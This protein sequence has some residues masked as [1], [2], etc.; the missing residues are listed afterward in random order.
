[1]TGFRT[2]TELENFMSVRELHEWYQYY[3]EEPFI[4]DRLEIQLATIGFILASQN[5]KKK[6]KHSEFMVSKK[7]TE[8]PLSQEEKNKQL[9]AA[10]RSM[11]G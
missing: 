7:E 2:V 11:K 3:N 10:F 1:M 8:K 4:A 6:F 5:S 9:I